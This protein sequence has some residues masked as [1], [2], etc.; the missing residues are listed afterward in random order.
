V[1]V[2]PGIVALHPDTSWWTTSRAR[3]FLDAHTPDFT[4]PHQAG[5]RVVP[6]DE[7]RFAVDPDRQLGMLADAGI[8]SVVLFA[9]C[10]YGNSYYPTDIGRRHAGLAGRDLFGEQLA[11]A[12]ARGMRVIAYYSN[13]WD[14]A[15]AGAHPEWR[16][17]T[18]AS[19]GSTGRW[20]AVCLRSGYREFASAQVRELAE[21][22]PIDALWSDI[23]TAGPCVCDSCSAAFRL[24]TGLP[25][26]LSR[27]DEGWLDLVAFSGSVLDEYL[28]EQR[29]VLRAARPSAA[30]IPNF[31]GTTFVD[32][33]IGLTTEHLRHADVGSSEGY[34]DWHG[35][36]F[37][38]FAA[39]YIRA[40]V[41]DRPH[42][43]LVSRFVHTWDFTLRSEAQLR[44]EAFTVAAHGATV[45][46]DDQP[47]ADGTLE[48]EVYRRLAPVFARI[49]ER[50]PYTV[51]ARPE[52]YA[53]IF[54]SQ[55]LRALESLLGTS[56]SPTEGEQSAQFPHSEPR[57]GES[58]LAAAVSG[59][60][61]S[62]VEAHL[63]VSFVDERPASLER[64]EDAAVLVLA[65]ALS[66]SDAEVAAITEFVEAGGGLVVTG[67]A[68]T[69]TATGR[70][71]P[72]ERQQLRDLLG[73]E[74]GEA[75][76]YTFPYLEATGWLAETAGR[77][78]IPHYGRVRALRPLADADVL[79]TRTD[80]VL[81]T[82]DG[83][84]WHNNKPAPGR[85]TVDPVILE[86]RVGDG[87]V[88]VSAA[89]LGNNRARLGNGVY[90]E[91]LAA[92][93]ERA[94]GRPAPVRIVGEHPGTEL[95]LRRS[96][97][98]L[99]AHLVT[100]YPVAG[101]D[102][103]GAVQPLAIEHVAAIPRLTLEVGPEIVR[104]AR[105]TG[106]SLVDLPVVA[107]RIELHDVDDWTTVV[108]SATR[109][110]SPRTEEGAQR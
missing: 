17:R 105:V 75:G 49:G 55:R 19:R 23:L 101:L 103:Y 21:R 40:G 67:P 48:P 95:V 96:G 54:A 69:H 42:E 35:L 87:R 24:R 32:A 36:G 89:R 108:L 51:D 106:R 4:D 31:Y 1:T 5:G 94:A 9:K 100:G 53:L 15:A 63:P 38:S 22:Y 30:L 60:Y 52:P 10:Q 13:M 26:P 43:V 62:L 92:L 70:V 27:D 83:L 74:F 39:E 44:F 14:V 86:R 66:L 88:I 72:P 37:P 20:D 93:V 71:L 46:V 45:S 7:V 28:A 104:A 78:P 99:V 81:E 8:D 25:V 2:D 58:D 97:D 6:A 91:L 80:P 107:G 41:L 90:R 77:W 84:F 59:S 64:L 47:Y 16:L 82:S 110:A 61:R 102:V 85:R 57:P 12:H 18:L 109:S 56:E 34:T 68:G 3:L 98:D 11:A 76:E 29:E 33:V 65:D 73:V 50:A 79:A